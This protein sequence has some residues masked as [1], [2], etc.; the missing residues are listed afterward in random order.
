MLH[1]FVLIFSQFSY[2]QLVV[3]NGVLIFELENSKCQF[4]RFQEEIGCKPASK[5]W[6]FSGQTHEKF[7]H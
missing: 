4:V 1:Q 3:S 6:R 7:Y 2:D 5:N